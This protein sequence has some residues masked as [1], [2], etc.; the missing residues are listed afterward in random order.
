MQ[1]ARLPDYETDRLHALADYRLLDTLPEALFD[2]ITAIAAQV[3]GVPISLISLVDRDRQWF[4]SNYG[5]PGVS[6]T[7]RDVAFC[8]H[9]ILQS[10]PFIVPDA[11]N[12]SRF[13]DNPLVSAE[14]KIRFY[15][16]IPLINRRGHGVGTLCVIDRVPRELSSSQIENLCRL[17]DV[18]L[19]LFEGRTDRH[20]LAE[21]QRALLVSEERLRTLIDASPALISYI[22]RNERYLLVNQ[23]YERWF[24]KTRESI[25]GTR[26]EDLIGPEA[27]GRAKAPFQRAL[28]GEAV[29]FENF[30]LGL[31]GRHVQAHFVPDRGKDGV[32]GVFVLS[33][34]ITSRVEEEL[35]RQ[36][37]MLRAMSAKLRT[38]IE[39]EQ[40]R[41]AYALHDQMGQD[42]TVLRVH[43]SRILRRW[44]EDEDLA[45]IAQQMA[46]ILDNTGT[47]IRRVIADL[48]PLALDDFGV[49]IAAKM[50]AREIEAASG[51]CIDFTT[52]GDFKDLPETHQI[53]LYRILQEC[54][55]NVVKHADATEVVVRLTKSVDEVQLTIADNGRGLAKSSQGAFG[56]YGLLGMRERAEQLSGRVAISSAPGQGTTV[57]STIPL[58]AKISND[59]QGKS[60]ANVHW[61][62]SF[63]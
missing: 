25:V 34:D 5:L 43:V 42:L 4:K 8:S 29:T 59:D 24:G 3:A 61:L 50:L 52:E 23:T 47:S 41:I 17:A 33:S 36:N 62:T 14:P 45:A 49:G 6:E 15:A 38:D 30:A 58:P 28:K 1:I 20:Q 57:T 54:L 56:H 22:D 13:A 44:H 16:G 18:V 32:R 10:Q 37:E 55:T 51:I 21:R 48:R 7:P 35:R 26:M 2:G 40:K 27:Y 63:N 31:D 11:L 19:A 46:D 53:G 12:D 39:A 9:A 60:D